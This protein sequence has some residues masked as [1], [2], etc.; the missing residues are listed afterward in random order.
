MLHDLVLVSHV[1][2]APHP[3]ERTHH[4]TR[5]YQKMST[6]RQR[7]DFKGAPD[8]DDPA[9]WDNRFSAGQDVGEWLNAGDMILEAILGDLDDRYKPNTNPRV[10][11]LGPGI[12]RMGSKLQDMFISRRWPGNGIVV[13]TTTTTVLWRYS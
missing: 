13:S 7:S 4:R 2:R 9:Y 10:L 5:F 3:K 1:N 6:G 8:Y 12:S 11:H